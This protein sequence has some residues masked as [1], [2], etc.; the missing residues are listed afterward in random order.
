MAHTYSIRASRA[1]AFD[2]DPEQLT[3]PSIDGIDHPQLRAAMEAVAAEL[4]SSGNSGRFA[5][6][7]LANVLAVH[8]I[9]HILAPRPLSRERDGVLS[10]NRLRAVVDYVEGHLQM[11]P[12]V[13]QMASI[14]RLSPFYFARQF[15]AATGLAPHHYLIMRR[16]ERAK[17]LLIAGTDIS[18]ADVAASAGFSDQSQF[19]YHF[20][21]MVGVTPKQ[22]RVSARIA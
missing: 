11:G 4:K 6:E 19:S 17:Q 5:V 14:A 22:Y 18:L 21:R 15:R 12:T 1:E 13:Q 10:R 16:V 7:S 2:L 3:M 8:L 9:R 20:K